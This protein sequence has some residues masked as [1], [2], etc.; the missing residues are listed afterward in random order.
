[1]VF[2]IAYHFLHDRA[3]AEEA[4]QDVFLQLHRHLPELETPEH[5]LFW[6]RKA[7]TRRAIDCWRRRKHEPRVS[8]E[9][10]P[11]PAVPAAP[12]DIMLTEKL[13]RLVASLP[14]KLRMTV[15]LRYQE[16]LGPTEIARVTG[17]PVR[18]VK[19]RL[20]QANALLREKLVRT[21]EE[22]EA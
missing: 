1:M 13:R 21:L 8:L 22:E 17:V 14:E 6:L 11:E 5:V 20:I 9:K 2:S 15:I 18:T 16:D 10:V 7:A 12:G 19:S 3:L 4:A